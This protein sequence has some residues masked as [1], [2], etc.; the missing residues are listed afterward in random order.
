MTTEIEVVVSG[1]RVQRELQDKGQYPSVRTGGNEGRLLFPGEFPGTIVS[2]EGLGP[3]EFI[4]TD[5]ITY[6]II[7][8][9]WLTSES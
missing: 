3:S 8:N 7:D 5:N 6:D 4:L 9:Q 1:G 2:P